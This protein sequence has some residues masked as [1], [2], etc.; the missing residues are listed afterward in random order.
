[1][2][3]EDVQIDLELRIKRTKLV[4]ETLKDLPEELAKEVVAMHD[5]IWVIVDMDDLRHLVA[6]LSG[7]GYKAGTGGA[8]IVMSKKNRFIVIDIEMSRFLKLEEML[9]ELAV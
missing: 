1:M 8:H 6:Y 4:L 2:K 5:S 3:K 9:N 7:R